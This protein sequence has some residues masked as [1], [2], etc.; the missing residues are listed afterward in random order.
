VWRTE[1][2]LSVEDWVAS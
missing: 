1:L 2:P